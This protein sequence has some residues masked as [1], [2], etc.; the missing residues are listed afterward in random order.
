[1]EVLA[2]SGTAGFADGAGAAAQ[3]HYP[4]GVAVDGEGNF[5]V[6]DFTN[7]R[8][9]KIAPDGTVSTLAGSGSAGFADGAGAAAQFYNPSGVAVDGEGNFIV[10]DQSNHRVRKI[11]P[12]GTVSTLAGSGIR[13]FADGAGAAAKN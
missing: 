3:F 6:A 12:D 7:N 11:A 1:M 5:I 2:G 13:G 4:S 8:L 9:R 10:A